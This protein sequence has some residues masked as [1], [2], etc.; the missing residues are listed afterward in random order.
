MF[1]KPYI[2]CAAYWN[3]V[4]GIYA[5]QPENITHGYVITG[6]RHDNCITTQLFF[7]KK[8]TGIMGFLTSDN[9]FVDREEAAEIAFEA[10]QIS[11]KVDIL[12]SEDLY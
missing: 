7:S 12:I 1:R 8:V 11:K 5:S 10:G 2:L 6:W 4:P 3:D 9:R